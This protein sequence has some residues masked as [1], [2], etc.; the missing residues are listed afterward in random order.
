MSQFKFSIITVVKNDE[1]N[2]LRTLKSVL[3]QKNQVDLE[4]IIIDGKS[5]DNTLKIIKKFQNE[6]DKIIS[7]NDS[8]I[9]DAMNKG[10][11]LSSGDIIAFCNSGDVLKE[12]GLLHVKKIFDRDK[13]DFVFGTIIR[14]YIGEKILKQGFNKKR[15]YFNFDF[16]TSHSCGFYIKK[17]I[18]DIIGKYNLKYKCSSDYDFYFR[19]INSNKF[20][21]GYTNKDEIVGEVASGGYSSKLT[22]IDHLIEETKIR[23]DNG[24]NKFFISIIFVNALIKNIFKKILKK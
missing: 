16:A 3:N 14:N 22:F 9:Y 6:V 17:K 12:H 10:I 11:S 7:E 1:E 21:G 4:Y 13:C 24:Q 18:I 20:T 5:S 15:I 8:G 23:I 2:I 19:L